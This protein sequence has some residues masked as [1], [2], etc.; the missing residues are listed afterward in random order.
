[1]RSVAADPAWRPARPQP[2][3]DN[4]DRDG[5]DCG[6]AELNDWLRRRA[7]SA[8]GLS[9]R[10]FVV[11]EGAAVI[12]Y[13]SLAT[14]AVERAALPTARLRRNLPESVPIVIL[15]RLAIDGCY[16]GRQLGTWLLR[17]AI[18]RTVGLSSEVGFRGLLVHALDE[19]AARFYRNYGFLPCPAEGVE[20]LILPLETAL[21]SFRDT[22]G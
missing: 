5:F 14:G 15:G 9:A 12:G 6:E 7:Q 20:T 13:Y 18:E 11:C 17:D 21:A 3:R 4:H 10:T 19:R 1:M 8:E 2:L 16:Q 22:R